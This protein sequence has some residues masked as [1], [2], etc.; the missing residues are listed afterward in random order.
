MFHI[1]WAEAQRKEKPCEIRLVLPGINISL[2]MPSWKWCEIE[3][4]LNV[5]WHYLHRA[6]LT[7]GN[8][9]QLSRQQMPEAYSNM[10]ILC[11]MQK[12]L[13][14]SPWRISVSWS[15]REARCMVFVLSYTAEGPSWRHP[16]WNFS[17]CVFFSSY[18]CLIINIS[19]ISVHIFLPSMEYMS[20]HREH[21][22]IER[23]IWQLPHVKIHTA[24][25]KK[26]K[27]Q[28]RNKEIPMEM[29]IATE[30]CELNQFQHQEGKENRITIQ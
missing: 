9:S 29:G 21:F 22:W 20:A 3:R 14:L 26:K 17:V 8:P 11:P 28:V 24:Y 27:K 10:K 6:L 4:F 2:G 13:L 7:K 1:S 18:S 25:I 16:S 19:V 12:S 23:N 5:K 30:S 15:F